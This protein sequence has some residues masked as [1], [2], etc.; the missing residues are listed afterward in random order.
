MGQ[1]DC[2]YGLSPWTTMLWRLSLKLPNMFPSEPILN[3]LHVF[4]D[5]GH[6]GSANAAKVH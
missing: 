2:H 1:L 4:T 6:A 3:A 5:Y